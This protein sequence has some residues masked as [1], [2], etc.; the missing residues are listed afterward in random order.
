M[1]VSTN[2]AEAAACGKHYL[3]L[4]PGMRGAIVEA[5]VQDRDRVMTRDHIIPGRGTCNGPQ[6]REQQPEPAAPSPPT[7]SFSWSTA[8]DLAWMQTTTMDLHSRSVLLWN[9]A[10]LLY[11]LEP[12]P[13]P[14]PPPRSL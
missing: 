13:P 12:A 14:T 5:L 1:T 9:S 11:D 10:G 2:S 6:C 4:S 3:R 7:T 8:D